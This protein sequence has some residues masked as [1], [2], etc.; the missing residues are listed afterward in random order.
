MGPRRGRGAQP[1]RGPWAGT[2][3]GTR[4]GGG[5]G[6]GRTA[7]GAQERPR[8]PRPRASAPHPATRRC[9]EARAAQSWAVLSP[10]SSASAQVP[11]TRRTRDGGIA[12]RQR[13]S[14]S[15]H[16]SPPLLGTCPS[17]GVPNLQAADGFQSLACGEPGRAAGGERSLTC[18]R[19]R[20]Q[21]PQ[22]PR[23]HQVEDH[24]LRQPKLPFRSLYPCCPLG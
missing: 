8:G 5:G 12:F 19:S 15:F 7:R 4:R 23:R 20:P 11:P 3:V 2:A 22:R 16:A 14:W 21:R 24:W 10:P 18:G 17:P 9:S 6:R 1:Q 13:R